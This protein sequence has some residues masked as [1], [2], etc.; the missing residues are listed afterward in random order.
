M[1]PK[2]DFLPRMRGATGSVAGR[3]GLVPKPAAADNVKY[4][5]GDG[6]WS[7]LS[8]AS[9][10]TDAEA[11]AGTST[12]TFLT[13]ANLQSVA[14]AQLRGQGALDYLQSDGATSNR[15]IETQYGT[16]GAVAGSDLTE[17]DYVFDVPTSNPAAEAYVFGWY[18]AATPSLLGALFC[19]IN[20]SGTLQVLQFDAAGVGYRAMSYAGFRA[21]Y[22]GR[23]VRFTVAFTGNS[24]TAP[25][26]YLDGVDISACFTLTSGSPPNWVPTT[27]STTYHLRGYNWPAGYF[28]PGRPVNRKFSQSDVDFV[29]ATGRLAAS[30]SL[31]GSMVAATMDWESGTT[32]WNLFTDTTRVS[33]GTAHGGTYLARIGY[34]MSGF[35]FIWSSSGWTIKKGYRYRV[36]FWARCATAGTANLSV[37]YTNNGNLGGIREVGSGNAF[38][39]GGLAITHTTWKQYETAEFVSLD[40]RLDIWNNNNTTPTAALDIDDITTTQLG[41]LSDPIIQPCQVLDDATPNNRA[42]ILVGFTPITTRK[43]W[44]IPALVDMSSTGNKQLLAGAVFESP[45]K[46]AIDTIESTCAGSPTFSI[47]DGTTATKYTASVAHTAIRLRE[48]VSANFPADSAKTGLY[49]NVT[50]LHASSTAELIVVRGHRE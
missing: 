25:V 9:A 1:R 14:N 18:A 15:R 6:S 37:G 49:A 47:G 16:L 12:T 34:A 35:S 27:L 38:V 31:G 40:D 2:P 33:D 36:R 42:S 8:N 46:Q 50:A 11:S 13:P 5:K 45:T 20:T 24:T 44:R 10:A 4:L 32:G 22:S 19:S 29:Q 7:A 39:H 48:T 21:A 41:A 26:V 43:D 28:R 23:R 3:R 17:A 30:D